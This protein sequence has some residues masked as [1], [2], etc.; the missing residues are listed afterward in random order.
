LWEEYMCHARYVEGQSTSHILWVG[1]LRLPQGL[2]SGCKVCMAN[3]FA[4][5]VT[6]IAPSFASTL[7]LGLKIISRPQNDR[8]EEGLG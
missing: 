7:S 2:N 4:H 6:S 5:L 8:G 3:A 1:F